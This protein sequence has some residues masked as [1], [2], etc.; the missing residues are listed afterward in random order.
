MNNTPLCKV[1]IDGV[2]ASDEMMSRLISCEV[3]DK[4]GVSA[5]TAK[6]VL[7]N[8]PSVQI[9]RRGAKAGIWLGY[10]DSSMT[11]M[12]T[13]VVD[14]VEL[15]L[16]PHVMTISAKSADL[17]Q[18]MKENKERHWDD[19]TLADIV[20][21][22]ANDHGYGANID[23]EIGSF[24]YPWFGQQDESDHAVLRRLEKTHGGLFSVKDDNVL[25]AK[26]GSGST[27][28]GATLS[29][30]VVSP[31]NIIQGSGRVSFADRAEYKSVG[32]YHQNTEEPERV[33]VIKDSSPDG[34]AIYKLA[35]PFATKAEAEKASESKA[36]DLKR[37][38]IKFSATVIGSPFAR[39]GVPL[40]FN[41]MKAGVDD[42]EFIIETAK[43]NWSKSGYS[44]ALEGKLRV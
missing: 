6:F 15:S 5:D 20:G 7:T 29:T 23:P 13:F 36:K 9:P 33:Q 44:T 42:I 22:I 4:E 30:F 3:T 35:E 40:V 31:L 32:A 10:S 11:F 16:F 21:E 25:F 26:R 37:Q 1:T 41:E 38:G 18:K 28:S 17:R 27:P 43:H 39:A 34:S 19:K 8:E 12:G 24:K 2:S 14:E